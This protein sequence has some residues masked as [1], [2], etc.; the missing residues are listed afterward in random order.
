MRWLRNTCTNR[1]RHG[2]VMSESRRLCAL[3]RSHVIWPLLWTT[4]SHGCVA[5]ALTRLVG[6]M[7]EQRSNVMNK[8][9]V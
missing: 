2:M 4:C 1:V 5:N 6:R 8:K 3:R 7:V 9:R